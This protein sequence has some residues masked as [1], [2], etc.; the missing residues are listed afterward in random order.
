MN[1]QMFGYSL[2]NCAIEMQPMLA[3]SS[4]IKCSGAYETA[5]ISSY[6]KAFLS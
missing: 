2:Y 3:L 6:L 1:N 4:E 5:P